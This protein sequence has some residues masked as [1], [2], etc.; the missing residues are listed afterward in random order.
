MIFLEKR[1]INMT[2]NNL[3]EHINILRK[4]NHWRRCNDEDCDSPDCEITGS[5]ELGLAIDAAIKVMQASAESEPVGEVR[6]DASTGHVHGVFWYEGNAPSI[7]T[8]VFFIPQS[9][10]APKSPIADS[11]KR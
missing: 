9:S 3:I 6:C 1:Q 8:K 5:K 4:H 10:D 2:T 11:S 7:G